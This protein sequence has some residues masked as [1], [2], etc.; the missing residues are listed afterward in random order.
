MYMF[1]LYT[2][3]LASTYI[4][5]YLIPY[6]YQISQMNTC[7]DEPS[8]SSGHMLNLFYTMAVGKQAQSVVNSRYARSIST[9]LICLIAQEVA[10]KTSIKRILMVAW[11]Q[12]IMVYDKVKYSYTG[13]IVTI[14]IFSF[15]CIQIMKQ[16]NGILF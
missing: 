14:F 5:L 11:I 8:S 15:L 13:M 2:C 12:L 6:I 9:E 16:I 4:P 7:M 3:V 10:I 1:H